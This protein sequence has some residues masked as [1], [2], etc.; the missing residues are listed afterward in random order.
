M[1]TF[2]LL[3]LLI[4][5]ACASVSSDPALGS[6]PQ[7][8]RVHDRG[9]VSEV[10]ISPTRSYR[11]SVV[12]LPIPDAWRGLIAAYDS[13]GLTVQNG[14]PAARMLRADMRVR[15]RLGDVRLS[16]YLHCGRTH[17]GAG[18]DH[19]HVHLRVETRVEEGEGDTSHVRTLVGATARPASGGHLINCSST[20]RLER[21][22]AEEIVGRPLP[23]QP[24]DGGAATDAA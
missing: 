23:V 18:A 20:G 10:V 21:R 1:P 13:L 14:D 16:T 12:P 8:A 2:L 17:G 5:P 15:G 3:L 11:A 7:T 4:L 9:G 19:Y 6:T 24:A 22:I